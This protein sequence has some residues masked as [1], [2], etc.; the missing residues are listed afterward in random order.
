[1]AGTYEVDGSVVRFTPMYG[2]DAGRAFNISVDPR[3]IPN[4]S[5]ADGWRQPML[6]VLGVSATAVEPATTVR[7][8]YP[9]GGELPENM[10]RFY[11]EFS[12]PMGR[13]PALEHIRLVDADGRD[14]VDPFLPVEAE[15][16]SPDRTRFTL[17]F[18][19]GRVKREIKP[20]RDMGRALIPGRRYALLVDGKWRDGRGVPLKQPHRHEFTVVPA[21]ERALDPAA[22]TIEPPQAG[23]REPVSIRFRGSSTTGSCSARSASAGER[24]R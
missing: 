17:F 5:A 24:R 1:M 22:W 15:F 23:T 7:Q 11:I 13:G 8:V 21:I 3:R 6:Q 20:N 9:S 16:W 10:L 19:P 2:F 14:V 12:A 4:A 18:D